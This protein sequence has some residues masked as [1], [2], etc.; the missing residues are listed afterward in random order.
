MCIHVHL[1]PA[2]EIPFETA[3]HDIFKTH[4]LIYWEGEKKKERYLND[5]EKMKQ[6]DKYPQIQKFLQFKQ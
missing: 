4:E 3:H 6:Q 5:F 1:P 2:S